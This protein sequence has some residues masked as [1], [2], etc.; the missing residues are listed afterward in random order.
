[1]A[2][3]SSDWT[4]RVIVDAS[5]LIG[6]AKVGRFD[7]LRYIFGKIVVTKAVCAEVMVRDDLPGAAEL[8]VAVASGW[9]ETVNTEIDRCFA[10]LGAGEAA[11]LTFAKKNSALVLMDD[12]AGRLHAET[13]QL[14][15]ITTV[16]V[17]I[18]AKRMGLVDAIGSIFDNMRECGFHLSDELVQDALD[19]VGERP[20]TG[21]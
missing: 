10:N 18:A 19:Q 11:T 2:D 4:G 14:D 1:M 3:R 12:E 20:E 9:A 21:A 8:K 17:L 6:L 13:Y 7:L 15:V 5:P 16:G